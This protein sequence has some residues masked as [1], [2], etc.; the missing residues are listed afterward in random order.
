MRAAREVGGY[1]LPQVS[2]KLGVTSNSV[3][4]WERG[5][6][7]NDELRPAIAAL[8]GVDEQ[9]LFHEYEARMAANRALLERPA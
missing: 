7:P 6:I 1:S 8:Y 5:S 3:V 2:K 4:Q 9:I